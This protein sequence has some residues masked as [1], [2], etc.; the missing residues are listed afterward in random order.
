AISKMQ[1]AAGAIGI[2]TA[3][4]SESEVMLKDGISDVLMTGVNIS[5]P[6]I[7][8]AMQLRKQFPGFI[9]AVDNPQNARDLND[10]A[11]AVGVIADIVVDINV[12]RRSGILPGQPALELAQLVDKL[13]N[14][15]FRGILAYDGGVQHVKGFEK[16]KT[17]A[18]RRIEPAVISYDLMK[19]SGLNLEIF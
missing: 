19:K 11:K 2:C 17:D 10:A 5:V 16:R 1:I 8:K 14:L 13:P 9:Q 4:L 6:K 7:R 12:A 18:I 3:K 15:N